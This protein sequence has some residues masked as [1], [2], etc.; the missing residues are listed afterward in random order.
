MSNRRKLNNRLAAL[1]KQYDKEIEQAF[2]SA[3]RSK[4]ASMDVREL[5]NAI[6]ARDFNRALRIAGLTRAE[7]Y[8]LDAAMTGA[9]TSGGQTI[10]ASA[11]SFSASFGFDGRATR[12][13]GWARDHAGGLVTNIVDEQLDMLRSTISGQLASGEAP[14][15]VAVRIAGKVTGGTRQGGIVGL[16]R[17]Q[18]E[19]LANARSQLGNLDPAYFGRKLRDRR[20]D[21]LV[22]KAI[23]DGKPLSQAD[24]DRIAGRY[25]DRML[26]HRADTIA[27][28]ESITALRAGRREGIQQGIEQGAIASD[29]IKRVWSSTLDRR[30]RKDHKG[31]NGQEV[32][33]MNTPFTFPDGSKALYPGDTSLGA[34][35]DQTVSCRCY[36]EYVVDFLSA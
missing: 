4:A 5:A 9:Y 3:V 25:S 22:K 26:K 28:T 21:S 30:T 2:L 31:M 19:Y 16:S 24:V 36:D 34:P 20:F 32:Q 33:G 7:L 23:A 8:P 13:A 1:L 6:E 35:S 15:S 18:G 12:A 29:K 17:A 27:R 10:A 14:R 11:P